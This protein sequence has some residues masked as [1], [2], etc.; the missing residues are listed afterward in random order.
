MLANSCRDRPLKSATVTFRVMAIH[1]WRQGL[2]ATQLRKNGAELI[3]A[4][5]TSPLGIVTFSQEDELAF[6][7]FTSISFTTWV[8]FGVSF[9]TFSTMVRFDCEPT[10]PFRVTTPCLTSYFTS[11]F[12]LCLVNAA[13]TFFSMA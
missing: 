5:S 1:T 12:H 4:P 8:T 10:L 13:F 6:L 7:F 9:T 2:A 3:R 11:W